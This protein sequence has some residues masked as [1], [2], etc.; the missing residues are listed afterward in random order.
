MEDILRTMTLDK[1]YKEMITGINEDIKKMRE[2]RIKC[3]KEYEKEIKELEIKEDLPAIKE[4][5]ENIMVL[6][7][8]LDLL[9][10]NKKEDEKLKNK[11]YKEKDIFK[12]RLES[13]KLKNL[14]LSK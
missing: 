3:E 14:T 5:K 2:A 9:N 11:G 4:L 13:W 12:Y 8:L 6:N 1:W 10:R 7:G